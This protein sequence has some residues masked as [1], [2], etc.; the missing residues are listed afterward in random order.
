[1]KGID[2]GGMGMQ[3]GLHVYVSG[4]CWRIHHAGDVRH[5]SSSIEAGARAFQWSRFV[6]KIVLVRLLVMLVII[7]VF[8]MGQSLVPHKKITLRISREASG[9]GSPHHTCV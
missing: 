9:V 8:L 1:M 6:N 5:G 2:M 3:R 4:G 7:I